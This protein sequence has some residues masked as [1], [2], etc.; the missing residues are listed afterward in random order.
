MYKKIIVGVDGSDHA[1]KAL[2]KAIELH[3]RDNSEIVVF[4][5]VIHKFSDFTPIMTQN[6]Y[7]EGKIIYELREDRVKQ[8]HEL[9]DEVKNVFER[10][11]VLVETRLEYDIGPQYYIARQVKN[12]GF[13]L[14]LLGCAGEHSKLKRTFLGTVPEYVLNNA[15]CDVLIVK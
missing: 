13:D 4:H 15:N 11:N 6:V 7:P 2:N 8:A 10:A 5:S 1:M 3:K 12:E 14:V 9:L